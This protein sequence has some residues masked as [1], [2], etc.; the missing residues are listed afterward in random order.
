[1]STDLDRSRPISTDLDRVVVPRSSCRGLTGDA[2]REGRAPVIGGRVGNQA[3][4][5]PDRPLVPAPRPRPRLA[6]VRQFIGPRTSSPPHTT[7]LDTPAG[8]E[9]RPEGQECV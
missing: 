4:T 6:S 3:P 5:A 1:M 9:E 7:Q 8:S 2:K